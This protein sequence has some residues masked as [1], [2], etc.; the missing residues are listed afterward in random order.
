MLSG[1]FLI[2]TNTTPYVVEFDITSGDM[3]MGHLRALGSDVKIERMHNAACWDILARACYVLS[4][5]EGLKIRTIEVRNFAD[6]EQS[7]DNVDCD[8]YGP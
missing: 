2:H 5:W 1:T 4:K 8:I 6:G 3:L 7:F